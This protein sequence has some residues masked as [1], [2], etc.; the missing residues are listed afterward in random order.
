MLPLLLVA[1]LAAP[2]FSQPWKDVAPGVQ[3]AAAAELGGDPA[4]SARVLL[5]DPAKATFLVRY[6]ASRPTVAQW[7]K[8]YPNAIAIA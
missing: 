5:I 8:R 6:D 4:W 1:L 3:A 7:Q 2:K